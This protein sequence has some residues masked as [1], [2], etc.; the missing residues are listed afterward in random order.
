MVSYRLGLLGSLTLLL[1]FGCSGESSS[2]PTLE[3]VLSKKPVA[4]NST[5]AQVQKA[6]DVSKDQPEKAIAILETVLKTD[7]KDRE[8]NLLMGLISAVKGELSEKKEER[9]E[10][11]HKSYQALVRVRPL[12]KQLSQTD[13]GFVTRIELGEARALALEGKTAESF[14]IVKKIAASGNE[15][16]DSID[17]IEDLKPLQ[18]LAEYQSFLAETYGPKLAQALQEIPAEIAAVKPFSF[19]FRLND[20]DGKRV[21]LADYRGKLT[22]VDFWGTWCPPCRQEIPHFVAL[23]K[24]YREKGLAIV[25]INC[26]E[27]GAEDEVVQRI[28][29]FAKVYKIDYKCLLDEDAIERKI[30]GFQGYPTTVF[31]DAAGKPRLVFDSAVTKAKL[32]AAIITLLAEGSK[33]P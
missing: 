20:L 9:I 12:L 11:F 27:K 24:K 7:P 10:Y 16:L 29:N 6:I 15:D 21:S 5:K 23:D 33:A 18:A 4:P 3:N 32:E 8:A 13:Q 22:I 28:R 19:D 25:G 2:D 14:A 26:Q 30:P 17:S 31:I 1:A